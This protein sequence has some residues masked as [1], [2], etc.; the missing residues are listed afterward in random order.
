MIAAEELNHDVTLMRIIANDTDLTRNQGSTS[1]SSSVQTAGKSL[2]AAAAAG[3][4]ALL[5][6][7]LTSSRFRSRAFR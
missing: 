6:L 1:N 7:A 3:Y 5:T 4:Q 2:R